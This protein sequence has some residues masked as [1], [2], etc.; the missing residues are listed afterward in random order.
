MT[1]RTFTTDI[2]RQPPVR[3]K[4]GPA[5]RQELASVMASDPRRG[6]SRIHV[7]PEWSSPDELAR[8]TKYQLREWNGHAHVPVDGTP[9]KGRTATAQQA[10]AVMTAGWPMARKL[11]SQL[12]GY[13]ATGGWRDVTEGV[14]K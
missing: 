4:E 11:R 1:A 5:S 13:A 2:Y 14:A 10:W 9:A 6:L 3:V 12:W 7:E 8:I